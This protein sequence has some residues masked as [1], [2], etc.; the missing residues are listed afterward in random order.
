MSEN[1]N[2][3]QRVKEYWPI[4]EDIFH[5]YDIWERICVQF[6]KYEDLENQFIPFNICELIEASKKIEY[7]DHVTG[8]YFK[9]FFHN[10][11]P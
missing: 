7:D 6:S 4:V 1:E 11:E 3:I 8:K 10:L 2:F 9:N 5:D